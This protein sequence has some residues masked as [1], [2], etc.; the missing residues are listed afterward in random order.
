MAGFSRPTVLVLWFAWANDTAVCPPY[1]AVVQAHPI[2]QLAFVV[3]QLDHSI[4]GLCYI[5][6]QEY[7]RVVNVGI[8]RIF[9]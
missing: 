5:E 3:D 2:R 9:F 6:L 7:V 8:F 1:L 4:Y